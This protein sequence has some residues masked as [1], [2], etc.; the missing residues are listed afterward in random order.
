MKKGR[1]GRGAGAG[2]GKKHVMGRGKRS[3]RLQMWALME[4]WL[5]LNIDNSSRTL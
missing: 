4:G 2:G 5:E 3:V 1:E